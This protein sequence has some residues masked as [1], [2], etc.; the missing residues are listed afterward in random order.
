M[1]VTPDQKLVIKH[2]F[3]EY[4]CEQV[5]ANCEPSRQRSWTEPTPTDDACYG[6]MRDI[7]CGD[8]SASG[9]EAGDDEFLGEVDAPCTQTP[10]MSPLH[11]PS[12][13]H[14]LNV[15]GQEASWQGNMPADACGN[16]YIAWPEQWSGQQ[17]TNGNWWTAVA[18]DVNTGLPINYCEAPIADQLQNQCSTTVR[19]SV[20]SPIA[21]NETEAPFPQLP[22]STEVAQAGAVNAAD[23]T[24][25]TVMLRGLP[26]TYT[27]TEVLRLLGAEGFFGRF[28]FVYLPIDFKRCLNLGYALINLISSK[29]ALRLRKRFE[30]FSN[31]E[32]PGG[33]VCSVAWCSPQQGLQAHVDRYRNSPVMHESVPEEWRPMLLSHGVQIT[34]PPP[35]IRIKAPRLKTTQ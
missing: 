34:F 14:H 5:P 18:I 20:L 28:N 31:W 9:S 19:S 29:E 3:L 7:P 30:G 23:E 26:E 15:M 25:T 16:E 35:T 10:E 12:T 6:Q 32:A 17:Y 22:S 27:R 11:G 8:G 4:V 1:G 13:R 2:T 24:R 21:E 33:S